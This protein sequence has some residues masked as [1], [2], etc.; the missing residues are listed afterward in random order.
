[1]KNK[2]GLFTLIITWCLATINYLVLPDIF[3]SRKQYIFWI[4]LLVSEIISFLIVVGQ[5]FTRKRIFIVKSGFSL[6]LLDAIVTFYFMVF[7]YYY[8]RVTPLLLLFWVGPVTGVFLSFLSY[9]FSVDED[10]NDKQI[11]SIDGKEVV[12]NGYVSVLEKLLSQNLITDNEY[13]HEKTKLM[14]QFNIRKTRKRLNRNP[15]FW[16]W[17]WALIILASLIGFIIGFLT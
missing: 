8:Y 16:Y 7:E 10:N 9:S 4:I 14:S 5:K 6:L 2:I 15:K 13:R 1:M 3:I 11:S 17:K 12:F